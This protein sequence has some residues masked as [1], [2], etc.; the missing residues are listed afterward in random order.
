MTDI[1]SQT[2]LVK[3]CFVMRR[4][5]WICALF[6]AIGLMVGPIAPHRLEAQ[7]GGGFG[8]GQVGGRGG[9]E[10]GGAG[11][12][13]LADF[14][15][16][17]TLIQ[18]TIEP[19]TWEA[20]GG[21]STMAPY[22]Q[23]ILVDARGLI[24]DITNAD[25]AVALNRQPV[26]RAR[27][28]ATL[29]GGE[30]MDR[31]ADAI[32]DP[33]WRSPA[34]VRCVS[35]RRLLQTLATP[36][37]PIDDAAVEN[38]AGLSRVAMVILTDDD[39]ILAGRVGGLLQTDGWWID[40]ASGLPPMRLSALACGLSSARTG[41]PFGCTIDPTRD[42]LQ[43][44]AA[45]TARVS[46]GDL[47]IGLAAQSL[48][49]ALG[50]QDV[51]VFGTG[52]RNEVAWLLIEADRH[53]KQLA[54]G[55]DAMPD[56]IRNYPATIQAESPGRPPHEL[57]LRLWFTGKPFAISSARSESTQLFQIAGDG[58]RLS[59]ENEL[60]QANGDRGAVVVDPITQTFVDHFNANWSSIRAQYPVYGGV[61][62]VF[63]AAA[64][65]AL[66]T[67]HA[68]GPAHEMMQRGLLHF[69]S[70]RAEQ[71]ATPTEVDSLAIL[72]TYRVRKTRHHLVLA[73]G[74]VRIASRELIDDVIDYP[75]LDAFAEI[76]KSRPKNRWW[77]NADKP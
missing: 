14:D 40:Q 21:T 28:L 22:P 3:E 17:M 27:D 43:R 4:S 42:G 55:L 31:Q 61:Q 37:Y 73:S 70:T 76:A 60:A 63:Q 75:S 62:T 13:A 59:G 65:G 23:G 30:N 1:S 11:G 51:R 12:G 72:H 35:V 32:G 26:D 20:L 48:A 66:W 38:M 50:R 54:L 77:W 53:M 44:A 41:D 16:L 64:I 36:D 9:A 47:P 24:T 52:P 45:V 46:G 33:D 15:S 7:T 39:L 25:D 58:L 67:G 68:S 56:G 8:G 57:L 74:G 34:A 18:S 71:L 29:I 49:D 19:D 69:A 2:R 6:L 10:G 5:I